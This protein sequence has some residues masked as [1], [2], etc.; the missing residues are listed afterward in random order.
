MQLAPVLGGR[1]TPHPMPLIAYGM[2]I[3]Q[4][5]V[6]INKMDARGVKGWERRD[7]NWGPRLILR[8]CIPRD[9][10]G[11]ELEADGRLAREVQAE[12]LKVLKKANYNEEQRRKVGAHTAGVWRSPSAHVSSLCVFLYAT[13]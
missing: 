11:K 13:L 10:W 5:V 2:G 9:L 1:T 3:R 7:R 4:L 8:P 6:A 12:V